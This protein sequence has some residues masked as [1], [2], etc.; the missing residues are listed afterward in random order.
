MT[1]Y[2]QVSS[3]KCDQDVIFFPSAAQR[4][5]DGKTWDL[6]I[7]GCIYEPDQRRVALALLRG[8]LGLEHSKMTELE[9]AL[10]TER[11]RLFMVDHKGGKRIVVQVAD[12]T[13]TLGKSRSDGR[14]SGVVHLLEADVDNL[15]N[16]PLPLRAVL[17]EKDPR[18]FAGEVGFVDDRGITVIS[19][20]DDTIKITNVGDR[21]AMLR[22][23]FLEPFE[24]VPGMPAVYRAW[25]EKTKAQFAYVSASP[26]QLFLPLSAFVRSNGFPAGTFYLKKFRLKDE[27]FWSLFQN[28]E[29]Y[30]PA[31]IEPLLKRFPNRRFVLVGDSGERDPEIYAELARQ[32]P[33][34]VM[35]IYIRDVTDKPSDAERYQRAF[36]DLPPA[37]WK[38][39]HQPAEIM[40]ALDEALD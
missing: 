21:K 16:N 36:H 3:V 19:D 14:F 23:T 39:F 38:I 9:N 7:H 35:R 1:G 25:A 2:S 37:R 18:Q 32:F 26:W 8:V 40:N 30:K 6:E 27:S 24:P 15:R 29:K 17:S 22:N 13:W 28:P 5:S 11:A 33:T 20:V 12:K 31:V 4:S 10:F 34:Q